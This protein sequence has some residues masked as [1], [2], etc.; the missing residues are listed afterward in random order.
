MGIRGTHDPPGESKTR[1]VTRPTK[2]N[3][4]KHRA[5]IPASTLS[6][7]S[8]S[9]SFRATRQ[10]LFSYLVADL[11]NRL[12]IRSVVNYSGDETE[13]TGPRLPRR[14]HAP[15]GAHALHAPRC[16]YVYARACRCSTAGNIQGRDKGRRACVATADG[17][18]GKDE[19]AASVEPRTAV[20]RARCTRPRH[21]LSSA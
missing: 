3:A 12:I 4:D 21:H 20:I 11:I 7:P 18:Y 14:T 5:R 19:R 13:D 6:H 17:R 1:L 16:T 2:I 8:I 10:L 15:T 9:V